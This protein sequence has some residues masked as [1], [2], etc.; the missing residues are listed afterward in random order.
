MQ[1]FFFFFAMMRF[2][3][4]S[5]LYP[6]AFGGFTNGHAVDGREDI[7]KLARRGGEGLE[8][9]VRRGIFSKQLLRTR[10]LGHLYSIDAWSGDR[11]DAKE[12]AS[13]LRKLREYR[14]N[15]TVVRMFFDEAVK[16]FDDETFDFIY[17]DGYAHTGAN[18]GRDYWKWWP[19]LKKGGLFAGHDYGGKYSLVT[20]YVDE[21]YE[22]KRARG[23]VKGELMIT[24]LP[25]QFDQEKSWYLI[26][27]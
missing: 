7:V 3:L 1:S 23:E 21:F 22:R 14:G 6:P 24:Q 20:K 8:L 5:S 16:L 9:G 2:I 11:H 15:S 25:D 12:Y 4:V 17:V 19:K 26:K 13:T 27:S 10:Q 18:R